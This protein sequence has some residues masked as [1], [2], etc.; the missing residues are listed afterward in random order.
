MNVRPAVFIAS[1]FVAALA[2]SFVGGFIADDS[3]FIVDTLDLKRLQIVDDNYAVRAQ[4]TT[5]PNDFSALTF[6]NSDGNAKLV[7]GMFPDG[8][9]LVQMSGASNKP[10]LA[11]LVKDEEPAIYLYDEASGSNPRIALSL[12]NGRPGISIFDEQKRAIWHVE[13]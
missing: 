8:D 12:L 6:F 2:G 3:N 9:P 11:M 13:Q 5:M 10:L 1:I 4:L 7:V